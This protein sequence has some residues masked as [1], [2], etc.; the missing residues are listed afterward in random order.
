MTL[1]T[2]V[3]AAI[4]LT[5]AAA[6]SSLPVQAAEGRH[7]AAAAGAIG[8]FALGALAGSAASQPYT[9]G[10]RVYVEDRGPDCYFESR[11]VWDDRFGGYRVR[12]IRICE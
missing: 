5:G 7:A 3:F 11:R 9:G 6:V 8:G 2:K 12:R 1:A 4:A 10:S